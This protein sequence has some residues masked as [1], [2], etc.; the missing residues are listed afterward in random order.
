MALSSSSSSSSSSNVECLKKNDQ[1]R[2]GNTFRG[3]ASFHG[4]DMTLSQDGGTQHLPLNR[5]SS[6]GLHGV[7]ASNQILLYDQTG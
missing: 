7:S 3:E 5:T 1:I 2:H 4:V 6:I